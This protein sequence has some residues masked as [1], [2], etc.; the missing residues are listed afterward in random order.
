MV[1]SIDYNIQQAWET[2]CMCTMITNFPK[3]SCYES[4]CILYYNINFVDW[5]F[6]KREQTIKGSVWR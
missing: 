1:K 3:E 6:G 2:T 5:C 4:A